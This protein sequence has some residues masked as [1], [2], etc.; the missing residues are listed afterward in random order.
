[1]IQYVMAMGGI[2]L[3]ELPCKKRLE[4]I[5]KSISQCRPGSAAAVTAASRAIPYKKNIGCKSDGIVI[6]SS[7]AHFRKEN[8]LLALATGSA[9]RR[10][11]QS[12]FSIR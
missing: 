11:N 2:V 12:V 6:L 10:S 1:L 3:P 9:S 5:A 8:Y 7:P 4:E